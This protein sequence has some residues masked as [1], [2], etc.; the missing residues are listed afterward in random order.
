MPICLGKKHVRW[1]VLWQRYKVLPNRRAVRV[2]PLNRLHRLLSYLR[3]RAAISIAVKTDFNFLKKNKLFIV[4]WLIFLRALPCSLFVLKSCS[5]WIK[6]KLNWM[7]IVLPII[8]V[9]FKLCHSSSVR[10]NIGKIKWKK[11]QKIDLTFWKLSQII[12]NFRRFF[13]KE[14]NTN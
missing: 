3:S 7:L 8:L 14:Y 12:F 2:E 5:H 9:L 6:M 10:I 11:C 1:F 4:N 13:H